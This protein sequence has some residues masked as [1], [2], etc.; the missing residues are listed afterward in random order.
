M[1][2]VFFSAESSTQLCE[3]SSDGVVVRRR[4]DRRRD[5]VTLQIL[6]MAPAEDDAVVIKHKSNQRKQRQWRKRARAPESHGCV[7][8][9]VIYWILPVVPFISKI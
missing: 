6:L 7:F 3:K 4:R 8:M 9:S 5:V 2:L 1:R